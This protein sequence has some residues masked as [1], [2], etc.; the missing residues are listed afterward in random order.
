MKLSVVENAVRGKSIIL[1]DDSIVRGTTMK[2]IIEML[3][4]AGAKEVHVKI[5]APPF[6]YPCFYGTDVPSSKQLIASEHDESFICNKIGAD[7]LQYLRIED[8]KDMVGDLPLCAA[9]FNNEYP[10]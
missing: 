7:S 3:R 2:K 1:I 10:A 8:F 5:S 6:L 9:C 4:K